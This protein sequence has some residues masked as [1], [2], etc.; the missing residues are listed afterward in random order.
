VETLADGK[1]RQAWG[2][3][4]QKRVYDEF[5][6]FRQLH[7]WLDVLS[8]VARVWGRLRS[9]NGLRD[10]MNPVDEF[11][12]ALWP[13]RRTFVAIRGHGR[14]KRGRELSDGKLRRVAFRRQ[15]VIPS[16]AYPRRGHA[17]SGTEHQEHA[18]IRI[19]LAFDRLQELG[20]RRP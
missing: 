6:I 3:T 17:S 20:R 12:A 10:G 5:L 4:D 11:V 18:P 13:R 14:A 1:R 19:G 16:R 8:A 2:R 9:V 15:F 7:D